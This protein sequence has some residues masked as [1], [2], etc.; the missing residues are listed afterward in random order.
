V[1]QVE[2]PLAADDF[3]EVIPKRVRGPSDTGDRKDNPDTEARARTHG[4]RAGGLRIIVFR[5]GRNGIA[6]QGRG[7]E[8]ADEGDDDVRMTEPV[9]L[10][11]V[12]IARIIQRQSRTEKK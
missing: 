7:E 6:Q 12:I 8:K 10:E 4:G 3:R 2:R 11:P 1:G 9:E 5:F